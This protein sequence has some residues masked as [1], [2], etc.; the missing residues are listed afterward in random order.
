[1]PSPK[2]KVVIF[3]GSDFKAKL[4]KKHNNEE[5]IIILIKGSRIVFGIKVIKELF[6]QR[7]N[8]A[9]VI[10][11]Y[12][13][14]YKQLWK[15]ITL[16]LSEV[17]LIKILILIKIDIYW[18]CHNIDRETQTNFDK[19][20]SFRRNLIVRNAK[21]IFVTDKML[22]IY[23]K[24]IF[25]SFSTKI[26]YTNFGKYYPDEMKEYKLSK[27]E[28]LVENNEIN[29]Y[30]NI[31]K[32]KLLFLMS[33]LKRRYDYVG[34]CAGK[35]SSKKIYFKELINFI[36]TSKYF[37]INLCV[38]V[39]S[40]LRQKNNKY[41]FDFL[42]NNKQIIFINNLMSFD[43]Y[44]LS[45]YFD[46]YWIGYDDISIPYSV[47]TAA[48]IKKPLICYNI[49]VLPQVIKKYKIGEVMD[50][51]YSNLKGIF[52][53]I[54]SKTYLYDKFLIEHRWQNGID[55]IINVN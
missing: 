17:C 1:M 7:K 45:N 2:K 54:N 51:D 13:N 37:K 21:Y 25:K 41:L 23:A 24:Q 39:V 49:G 26:R 40:D 30:K 27:T 12:L 16:F 22:D 3:Q 42:K 29:Y 52:N 19:L 28:Y 8:D 9:T 6:K 5:N 18:I 34:F 4:W 11:R 38:V 14:D 43:E 55:K 46:F 32:Q 36:K 33:P 15:S 35:Y 10:F 48:S 53:K 20:L 44:E 31:D 50:K 47:Y